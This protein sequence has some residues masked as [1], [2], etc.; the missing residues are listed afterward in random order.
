ME[1]SAFLDVVWLGDGVVSLGPSAQVLTAECAQAEG[2]L[3]GVSSLSRRS[4][5]ST[6]KWNLGH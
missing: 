1:L 4:V 2:P 6:H 5:R 3:H